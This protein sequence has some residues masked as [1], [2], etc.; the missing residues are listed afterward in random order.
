[1]TL[2]CM[3]ERVRCSVFVVCAVY[4]CAACVCAAVC[5]CGAWLRCMAM[6]MC[7]VLHALCWLGVGTS[8][9]GTWCGY[10]A[11]GLLRVCRLRLLVAQAVCG[12]PVLVGAAWCGLCG[13]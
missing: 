5:M 6:P 11:Y 8:V 12:V 2:Q 3:R 4:V 10:L 7:H 9:P 1:M 13:W